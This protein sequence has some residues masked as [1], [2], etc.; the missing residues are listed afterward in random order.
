MAIMIVIVKNKSDYRTT[1]GLFVVLIVFEIIHEMIE[2]RMMKT[3][4]EDK[5]NMNDNNH[6]I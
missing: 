4:N 1:M 2:L 6:T 5:S 3:R